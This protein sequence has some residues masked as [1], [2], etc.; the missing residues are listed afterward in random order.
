MGWMAQGRVMPVM[1]DVTQLLA[2]TQIVKAVAHGLLKP[3]G[4]KFHVTAKGGDRSR[5][6]VQWP[7]LKMFATLLALTVAGVIWAFL[8]EDGSKLRNSSALCLFWSWYNILILTIA[9]VVCVEQPRLR[10]SE[11]LSSRDMAVISTAAGSIACRIL[12]IS[13]GGAQLAG[14][15]PAPSGTAVSIGLGVTEIP[16]KIL[17]ASGEGFA[18]GF[19]HSETTRADLI[20]FVYSGRYSATVPKIEPGRVAAAVFRRVLR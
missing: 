7:L 4:H 11:R 10:S 1:S 19:V 14:A 12:D 18:V 9:C 17:R 3:K 6:L 13:L 16:G 2:A 5:R 20:R 8:F 15:A